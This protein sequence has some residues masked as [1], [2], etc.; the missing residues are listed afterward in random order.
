VSAAHDDSCLKDTL[1][2]FEIAIDT[3]LQNPDVVSRKMPA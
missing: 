2:G 1:A 3:T